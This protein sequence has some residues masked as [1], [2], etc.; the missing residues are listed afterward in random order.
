M[1]IIHIDNA[2]IR[3]D[4]TLSEI[5][6]KQEILATEEATFSAHTKPELFGLLHKAIELGVTPVLF[7]SK[8]D[9]IA[10]R[11]KELGIGSYDKKSEVSALPSSAYALFFTSGTTGV[12]T[13]AIKNRENV[14]GELDALQALF[15]PENFERVVVTVPFIHIYGFLAG[16]MLPSRLGCEI[17][18]K[19]EYYPQELM[20]LHEHKK[21]LVVTSPVYI[22]ALLRLK[23]D[24]DL[25]NVTFLSSTG[26]LVEEEVERFEKQY[27]TKLLQLFG[28]TETGGVAIKRGLNPYWEPLK[29]VSVTKNHE[30]RMVVDSPYLSSHLFEEKITLMK[31]PYTT[32][33]IIELEGKKFKLLGRANEII[34]V[35]GKRISIV[36]LE[37]IIENGFGVADA[38]ISIKKDNTKLKD[39]SL[40]IKIAGRKMPS[41]SEVKELFKSH[42]PEIN[43]SFELSNVKSIEKNNMGKKVRR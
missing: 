40:E 18:L 19:E 7:D 34:K 25:N 13:G 12:P 23:R 31:R 3:N 4:S 41:E 30:S 39:E 6:E 10:Q 33:D 38:L 15:A 14:E 29:G 28:S 27:N 8:I 22:K 43:F 42:Y 21:T 32:T 37:N 2:G 17:L 9:T 11:V 20:T 26:L 5:Q 1:N 16:L 36:E 24:H 35:S